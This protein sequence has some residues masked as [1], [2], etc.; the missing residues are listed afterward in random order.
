MEVEEPQ[1]GRRA[2][3]C[4]VVRRSSQRPPGVSGKGKFIKQSAEPAADP[5]GK[6]KGRRHVKSPRWQPAAWSSELE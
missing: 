2:L 6:V 3:G 5:N 4:A 1:A